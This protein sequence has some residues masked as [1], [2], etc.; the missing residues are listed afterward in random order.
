MGITL[1]SYPKEDSMIKIA[2]KPLA[3]VLF[4][5]VFGAYTAHAL[6]YPPSDYEKNIQWADVPADIKETIVIKDQGGQVEAVIKEVK[7]NSTFYEAEVE[8]PDGRKIILKVKDKGE[9]VDL[10]YKNGSE[11]E[12]GNRI[13]DA[14]R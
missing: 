3:H 7:D 9:L 6:S 13:S 8:T 1:K 11:D 12:D 2:I 14:T 10:R 4:L 5:T